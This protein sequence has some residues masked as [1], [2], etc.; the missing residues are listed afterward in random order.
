MTKGELYEKLKG[1]PM[2]AEIRI[3]DAKDYNDDEY[4]IDAVC[5]YPLDVAPNKRDEIDIII[6]EGVFTEEDE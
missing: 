4:D 3:V 5:T 6:N 1:I 2:D